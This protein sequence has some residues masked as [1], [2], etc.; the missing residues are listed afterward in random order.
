[1]H[2]NTEA[3]GHKR[4]NQYNTRASGHKH[5]NAEDPGHKHTIAEALQQKYVAGG[6]PA[7]L[8]VVWFQAVEAVQLF[9]FRAEPPGL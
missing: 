3:P 6:A 8:Q 4:N 2:T 9:F 5:N 1:M 7:F